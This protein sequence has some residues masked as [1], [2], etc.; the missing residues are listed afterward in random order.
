MD[1]GLYNHIA[2]DIKSSVSQPVIVM[3]VDGGAFHY[4]KIVDEYKKK[5]RRENYAIL[6]K[7]SIWDKNIEKCTRRVRL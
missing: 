2:T 7:S 1:E 4:P 6:W 3:L 5:N